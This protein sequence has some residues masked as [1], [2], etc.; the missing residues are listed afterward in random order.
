MLG[1]PKSAAKL[2]VKFG[3]E[4]ESRLGLGLELLRMVVLL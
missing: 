4:E 1:H 2:Y 3:P